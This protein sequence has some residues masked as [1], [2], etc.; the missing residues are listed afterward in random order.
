MNEPTRSYQNSHGFRLRCPHCEQALVYEERELPPQVR[1]PTCQG[2]FSPDSSP[3][4]SYSEPTQSKVDEA[5]SRQPFVPLPDLPDYE[6]LE[7]I[8]QGGMGVVY[9]ARDKRLQRQVAIKM[10]LPGKAASS[11]QW[12][13]LLERFRREA[14]AVARLKHPNIVPIFTIEESATGPFFVMELVT[15]GSLATRIKG[16]PQDPKAAA[17]MVQTLALAMQAAHQQGIVHRD[18]KPANILMSDDGVGCVAGPN[19]DQDGKSP[20]QG[21]GHALYATPKIADFGLAKQLDDELDH[22]QTV[23]VAGTPSYMAP[24]QAQRG[25]K[26]IGPAADIYALGAILYELLT[27]QPPFKGASLLDT[28]DQVRS[29]EPVPP[30]RL[31][32]RTPFDLEVI[33]LKCLQKEPRKRYANAGQL[34]DD[35]GRFLEGKPIL[36]RPVGR[37]EIAWKWARRYPARAALLVLSLAAMV[38]IFTAVLRDN[39]LSQQYVENLKKENEKRELAEKDALNKPRRGEKRPNARAAR[40]WKKPFA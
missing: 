25:A 28:L 4:L 27:G 35:L 19:S 36:A 20:I 1:C 8:G 18:L 32:P 33:C 34:A 5:I 21:T 12:A 14:A 37:L 11:D 23:G 13:H 6:I 2:V 24:E 9:K 40:L 15:G 29:Q 3:T 16:V 7:V 38:G 22:T 17:T 10:I 26:E 30:T 31:Q 39:I